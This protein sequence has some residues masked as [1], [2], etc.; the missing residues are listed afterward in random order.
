MSEEDSDKNL[1]DGSNSEKKRFK[2]HYG[3]WGNEKRRVERG[4]NDGMTKLREKMIYV[5]QHGENRKFI[6]S[7]T[8]PI[9]LIG[10]NRCLESTQLPHKLRE[11]VTQKFKT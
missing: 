11:T 1:G 10:R 7:K 5:L 3:K 6:G 9:L 4:T 8:T 2:V